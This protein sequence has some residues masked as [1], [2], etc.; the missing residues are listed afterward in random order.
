MWPTPGKE[1]PST[2]FPVVKKDT[3]PETAP[4]NKEKGETGRKPI[5]STSIQKKIQHM[6]EAKRKAVGWPWS[7]LKWTLCPSTK[8]KSSSKN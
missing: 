2:A 1:P 3:M 5:S 8:D 7:K 4:D 6:K